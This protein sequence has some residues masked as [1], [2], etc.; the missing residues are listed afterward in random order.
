MLDFSPGGK[1]ALLL[2]G[3]SSSHYQEDQSF[4]VPA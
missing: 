4:K 3:I 2:D 1:N